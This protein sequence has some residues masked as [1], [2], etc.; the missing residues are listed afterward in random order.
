MQKPK[1]ESKIWSLLGWQFT[2][3]PDIWVPVPVPAPWSRRDRDQI[4]P[5]S[6]AG[7]SRPWR[8]LVKSDKPLQRTHQF[9]PWVRGYQPPNMSP[10]AQAIGQRFEEEVLL[11]KPS[12][13]ITIKSINQAWLKIFYHKVIAVNIVIHYK[14]IAVPAKNISEFFYCQKSSK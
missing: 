9:E 1:M 8:M 2:P 4:G 5:G 12:T 13:V 7:K 6:P 14:H 3:G 11:Q 10:L